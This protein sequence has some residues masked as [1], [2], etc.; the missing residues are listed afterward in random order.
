M[1]E[2]Q[3]ALV[4]GASGGIGWEL[5]REFAA[6]GYDLVLVA[7][8]VGKLEELAQELRSRHQATVR[9]LPKDLA[10]PNS[11][12]EVFQE[13]EGA[14]ATVDVLVNNAGFGTFG[15]FSQIELA[16]ELEELQLN[17]VTLT[18]LTKRFLP[19]M[20][21]RRRG[22]VLNVASTAAFQPGPFMAVYYA[23]KAYVLSFSEALA[24]EMQETG[25]VISVLCPGPTATGFTARAGLG[26]SKLQV[27][28][29]AAVARAGYQ[30]FREGQR[31]VIPGFN[32]KLLAESVRLMPRKLVTKIVRRMQERRR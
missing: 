8:T 23:T 1:S 22:G 12:E 7:R 16:V 6:G 20:L 24:E 11:A 17:V 30:G 29:A 32:N 9:V 18:H 13:L 15:P 3:T 31:I 27:S 10:Q 19:G 4:T 14:G 25:V 28:N 21:A 5:A 2:R 26:D